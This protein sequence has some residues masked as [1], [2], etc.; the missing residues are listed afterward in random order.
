MQIVHRTFSSSGFLA[1]PKLEDMVLLQGWHAF[2]D[3]SFVVVSL[4]VLHDA[5]PALKSHS[6]RQDGFFSYCLLPSTEGCNLIVLIQ[7]RETKDGAYREK[8]EVDRLDP[9]KYAKLQKFAQKVQKDPSLLSFKEQLRVTITDADERV[10]RP[11]SNSDKE[12][13]KSRANSHDPNPSS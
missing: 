12:G 4:D 3:G 13:A 6:R 7:H 1:K 11:R 10:R 2:D 9:G 8:E 5:V